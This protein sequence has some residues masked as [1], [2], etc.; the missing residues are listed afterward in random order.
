MDK[1]LDRLVVCHFF[2]SPK[3]STVAR[4]EML[5]LPR[6]LVDTLFLFCFFVPQ[7]DVLSR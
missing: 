4:L 1:L 3:I 2:L 5:K 6:L 7:T